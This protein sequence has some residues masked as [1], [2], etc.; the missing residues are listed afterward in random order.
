MERFGQSGNSPFKAVHLQRWSSLT[1]RSS[2]TDFQ[3]FSFANGPLQLVTTPSGQ[4][5]GWFRCKCLLVNVC[6]LQMQDLNFPPPSF[7]VNIDCTLVGYSNLTGSHFF[8]FIRK[9]FIFQAERVFL[10]HV[11]YYA[12]FYCI[13]LASPNVDDVSHFFLWAVRDPSPYD[14]TQ[15]VRSEFWFW[16]VPFSLR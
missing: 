6:K 5:G 3:K 1:V 10:I 16:R 13:L 11:F 9:I 8:F 2:P 15:S 12:G 4:N 7:H 14:N